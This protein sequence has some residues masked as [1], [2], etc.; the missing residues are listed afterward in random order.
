MQ[1]LQDRYFFKGK[2]TFLAGKETSTEQI[3]GEVGLKKL[4]DMV[5]LGLQ[6]PAL[7]ALFAKGVRFF[8]KVVLKAHGTP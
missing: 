2:I 3:P 7:V 6:C 5:D 1:T 8:A 4:F